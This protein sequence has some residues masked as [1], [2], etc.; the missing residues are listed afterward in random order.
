MNDRVILKIAN[1][2]RKSSVKDGVQVYVRNGCNKFRD[3]PNSMIFW[4]IELRYKGYHYVERFN[5]SMGITDDEV[6]NIALS[7]LSSLFHDYFAT[8][9]KEGQG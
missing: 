1:T 7:L 9:I 2:I 6:N 4:D 5:R 8:V 3:A